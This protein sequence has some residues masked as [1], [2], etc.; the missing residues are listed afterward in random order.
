MVEQ[1]LNLGSC[2]LGPALCV[3]QMAS[4]VVHYFSP[5]SLGLRSKVVLSVGNRLPFW[6]D[7][8]PWVTGCPSSAMRTCFPATVLHAPY[9]PSE[10]PSLTEMYITLPLF[11]LSSSSFAEALRADTSIVNHLCSGMPSSMMGEDYPITVLLCSKWV[12][13]KM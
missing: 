7:L 8:L 9:S 2:P 11:S 6:T 13:V 4:Y 12:L 10:D 5:G 3:S 1:K